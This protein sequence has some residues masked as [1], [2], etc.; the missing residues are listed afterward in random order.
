VSINFDRLLAELAALREADEIEA[1]RERAY[2]YQAIDHD[3][4]ISARRDRGEPDRIVV[5]IVRG[6]RKPTRITMW[7]DDFTSMTTDVLAGGSA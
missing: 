1:R 5:E 2:P 6:D 4:S 7:V 3:S